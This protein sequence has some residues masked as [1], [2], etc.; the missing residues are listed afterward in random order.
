MTSSAALARRQGQFD[1]V[2]FL[3]LFI[4]VMCLPFGIRASGWVPEVDR[5]LMPPVWAFLFAILLARSTLPTWLAWV[6]G[7]AV[8][9]TNSVQYATGLLPRAGVLFRE[10]FAAMGWLYE[11]VAY[12]TVPAAVP[13][14]E[15]ATHIA[16][17]AEA[18]MTAVRSW[19]TAIEAGGMSEDV[20]VLWFL[21][22]LA[23]WVLT[24]NAT[25]EMR[26]NQRP[27]AA[28][29]PLGVALVSNSAITH[30]GLGEVQV[31]IGAM[32]LIIAYANMTRMHA[33][34]ERFGVDFSGELR[35]D[36]LFAGAG[37]ATIALVLAL[38]TPYTTYNRAVYLFWDRFGPTLESFYDDL[39][40]AF[41]GRNP[42]PDPPAS[43]SR[44]VALGILP[45]DVGLGSDVSDRTVMLVTI[46][47]PPPPPLDQ[48]EEMSSAEAI[49]PRRFVAR[50]Y[51]R[52]R[53]YDVYNGSGWD[54]SE[55]NTAELSPL[56]DWIDTPFPHTVLT[57]TYTLL[58]VRGNIVFG[59]N[60]PV[61]VNTGYQ[62]LYRGGD[63][64]VAL[65]VDADEYTVVSHV[66]EPTVEELRA[67]EAPYDPVIAER[68]LALPEIPQRVA[69]LAREIVDSAGAVTR[70][71]KARAI[72][73]YLRAY[74]YDLDLAPPP[75]DQDIVEYFLFDVQRGYCDYSASAMVVLLR[76]V[77]VA[78]RYASGYGMGTYNYAQERWAVTGENA[79]AWA[80]VYFPGLGW[81]EFEP[82]PTELPREFSGGS[83][84]FDLPRMPLRD[85]QTSGSSIPWRGI[86]SGA[87]GLLLV[88]L[89]TLLISGRIPYR[90][91]RSTEGRQVIWRI[92]SALTRRAAWL[93][94]YP[95]DGQTPDEFLRLVA[96]SAEARRAYGGALAEDV[97][98]ISR[99]Y[100]RARYD[101]GPISEADRDR[102]VSAWNRLRPHLFGLMFVRAPRRYA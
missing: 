55:R 42:V 60:E 70:Y 97:A 41:A 38:A 102:A 45:H 65:V 57:Q 30:V 80:E 74:A 67:A 43:A 29:L 40:R 48:L 22:S 92:Y 9:I 25:F 86:G 68:Y 49:D 47:D 31:F 28:L 61:T 19:M 44:G 99:A 66:P 3:L 14:A 39:D 95:E 93:K 5:L 82:T 7:V 36:S 98:I 27:L 23:V 91:A 58:E 63:D 101:S 83:E 46:S 79:H 62:V 21:V 10:L 15:T 96:D 100:T 72:E 51:W 87:L 69:D 50:R 34:W 54:T 18:S 88:G 52:Q 59:V 90:P 76:S 16:A 33:I 75:L 12:G 56:A 26:R 2:L 35:R 64:L 20:T 13:F 6:L 17:Q 78:S 4:A 89:V 37:I 73:R 81:I 53:T 71:E 85:E 1:W 11:W 32:L 8:G 77:G 94:V 24:W 84:S